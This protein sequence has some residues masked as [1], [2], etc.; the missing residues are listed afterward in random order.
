MKELELSD[1]Q[2]E[3]LT[4]TKKLN[5]FLSGQGGGKSF[6]LGL[7]A[8]NFIS[9]FPYVRGMICSNSYGQLTKSTLFRA[10]EVWKDY[11][12]WNEYTEQNKEGC[13]VTSKMPPSHFNT[14]H[15]NFDSY[16]NI[17]SFENGGIIYV[18]SLDAYKLLDGL[19]CGWILMDETK[20]T[21]EAALK[22]VLLARARQKGMYIKDSIICS[23]E[24]GRAYNPLFVFTSPSKTQWLNKLFKLEKYAKEI[25]V[26][27]FSKTDFFC[28]EYDNIKSVISSTYINEKNLPEPFIQDM[29]DTLDSDLVKANVF[30]SPFSRIGGEMYPY[31]EQNK[32]VKLIKYDPSLPLFISFDENVV[33]YS[34][35]IIFQGLGKKLWQIEEI[36]LKDPKNN[37]YE[38]CDKIKTYYPNHNAGM[39]IC[40]DSTSLKGDSKLKRGKDKQKPNLYTIIRSELQCYAPEFRLNRSNP[41]VAT[42]VGFINVIMEKGA[43]DIELYIGEDCPYTIADFVF[44]KKADDGGKFKK[45]TIDINTGVSYQE[46][47]HFSDCLDYLIVEFFRD[48]YRQYSNPRSTEYKA[49]EIMRSNTF[50]Y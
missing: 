20:N 44:L 16:N 29:I 15:H 1:A 38:V 14:E 28:K 30:G 43:F 11:L 2:L 36:A 7:K 13:Y 17:I 23:D 9:E 35:A 25:E 10:R 12:N 49:K 33:P 8:A 24:T 40:G 4:S 6:T 48:E 46:Y 50:K 37:I 22:E 32:H 45:K 3:I 31:F 34:P 42:R 47:G 5:L 41:P 27:V 26:K 19:E 18:G 21:K 39:I